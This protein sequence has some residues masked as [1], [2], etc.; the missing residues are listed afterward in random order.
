MTKRRAA[1]KA[2]AAAAI[3]PLLPGCVVPPARPQ[4]IA[5]GDYRGVIGYL[6]QFIAHEM[7][8]A[9]VIGLSIAVLD[10]QQQAWAEGFGYADKAA[11]VAATA[12]TRYRAG[13]I[14]KVFTAAAAMQLAEAGR[15]DIDAPLERALP[16]FSIRRRAADAAPITPRMLMTHHAGLP[17]DY[18]EG[19]WS[20]RPPH[21]TSVVATLRDEYRTFPPDFIH[22]YSNVGFTLLGAA[23]EQV[24]G[25]SFERI[26]QELLLTPLAMTDSDFATMPPGGTLAYDGEGRPAH[27]PSLRDTPAGGLNTTAPD[28]L[29]L[30]RLWFAD[31]ELY[32]VR[33]LA[34]SSV[35]EMGRRQNAACPLDV[36]M[37]V[38]LG[39]HFAPDALHGGGPVLLHGG[40]TPHYHSMLMLLPE[41]RLAVAV[42]ANSA[43]AA[44]L[45]PEV[46]SRALGLLLE[47]KTGIA[48][49]GEVVTVPADT[50]FAAAPPEALIGWYD[51]EFGLTQIRFHGSR[52]RVAVA[53]QD[54]A[55][56][57]RPSG[58]LG[59]EYWLTGLFDADIGRLGKLEFTL[60]RVAGRDVLLA[61]SFSGFY[62]A[63]SRIEA[64]SIPPAWTAR[65]GTYR[66]AGGDSF[67]AAKIGET[68]LTVESGFLLV[69]TFWDDGKVQR[70][71]LEPL[72]DDEAIVSGLGR[73]RGDTLHVRHGNDGET[74]HYAGLAFRRTDG[75]QGS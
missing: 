66:Y 4:A 46:A 21:F 24:A 8:A 52:L 39:W 20:D 45:V 19:M 25:S 13:S 60:A 28:L 69:E 73:G 34:A 64:K 35:A 2:L 37:H 16:G 54:L 29:Q 71:A 33:M 72:G 22:A 74:L 32:G 36:D 7:K 15:L 6:R 41:H 50:R 55:L 75:R 27:E 9:N 43:N 57:P 47:A 68:G 59:L 62:L 5:Q 18:V 48:Q 58:Y 30:A 53:G 26:M 10:G 63:G 3:A 17:S 23:I 38:G 56:T 67:D 44:E 65:V 14:S 1:L 40:G 61:R 11:Q 70:L 51:T 31:G 12:A 49:P 42:M